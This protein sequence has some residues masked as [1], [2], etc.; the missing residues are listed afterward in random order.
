MS[1]A[2]TIL[3]EVRAQIAPD[4]RV[5][6][7]AR[8]R[9]AS[10]RQ[11]AAGFKG[12]KR[13]FRSGSV[14]HMT[15]NDPVD[16]ADGGMVLDR[17]VYTSLGPDGDDVGPEEIV[18]KVRQHLREKLAD[19]FPKIGFRLTKRAIKI[20]FGEPVLD[21]QDPTVDLIVALTRRDK[22][23]LWIPQLKKN[24]WDASHPEAHTEL[25]EDGYE[26]TGHVLQRAV[27]LVKVWNRHFSEPALS[28]FNIEALGLAAIA[29]KMSLAVATAKLFRHGSASLAEANTKDPAGVSGSIRILIDRDVAVRRLGG[30]AHH[31][32][33]AIEAGDDEE[34][35]KTELAEVFPDHVQVP[36]GV[37][38]KAA[39]AA[40]LT[41]GAERVRVGQ[42]GRV[43]LGTEGG[44]GVKNQRSFGADEGRKSPV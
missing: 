2:D 15:A 44:R 35:A 1:A 7:A 14:A 11:A 13:T 43:S 37:L 26:T 28:S 12:S 6:K 36:P 38:S 21:D 41:S 17:T 22:P 27:R 39:L 25:L 10:V 8:E 32:D 19:R 18:E 42:S 24:G 9:L 5:L 3:D 23:G 40:A 29:E 30:A 16:D 20:S 33:A 34:A 4:D 31:C